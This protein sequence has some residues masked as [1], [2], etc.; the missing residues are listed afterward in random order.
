MKFLK[1]FLCVAFIFTIAA[2]HGKKDTIYEYPDEDSTSEGGNLGD[3]CKKNDDCKDGLFCINK[4]CSKPAAD[5]DIKDDSDTDT[6]TEDNETDSDINDEDADTGTIDDSDTDTIDDSDSDTNDEDEP[7][8]SDTQPDGDNDETPYL[9]ECGNGITEMGEECDNG[10]ANSDEPGTYNSTCRTNCRFARCGDGITD[11]NEACDDGNRLNGDYCSADCSEIIGYCGDGK[12]QVEIE[13]CD[14]ADP[15][16]GNREGIGAYCAAD[17]SEITGSCGDGIVQRNEACDNAEPGEGGGQG[18]GSHYCSDN[19]KEVTGYCG[20]GVRQAEIEEC[21]DGTNNGKYGSCNTTCSGLISCGDGIVQPAYEKCDDGNNVNGDYCSADCQTLYGACGDGIKQDGIEECDTALDPYCSSDCQSIVG[22]CGDGEV[23]GNEE[24]DKASLNGNTGCSYGSI[25]WCE[26]CST[27]CTII[28]GTPIYCGDG[29]IQAEHYEA[30]DDGNNNNNDYCSA[31]CQT[32]TGSCGDGIKQNNEAC[33]T[34]LDPYCSADCKRIE[35]S[36]GDGDKNGN[37]E[38]DYGTNNGNMDCAYDENCKVCTTECKEID[39]RRHYCG[40]HILDENNENCD[41]GIELNG[42]YNQCKSD[43]SGIGE[44]CG[45]GEKNG[46]E[47]CD[48]GDGVNGTITDCAYNEQNCKVCNAECKL[49]DGNTSTC[50]DGK[51]DEANGEVC[52]KLNDPYCSDECTTKI[53]SCGDGIVQRQNCEGYDNCTTITENLNEACDD[54]NND[55]NDYCSSDCQTV[56]GSCG[57]ETK[58]RNEFCESGENNGKYKLNYPPYCNE[59]CSGYSGY[60][61][62]SR[63]QRPDCTGYGENC[64]P[65]DD[66]AEDCDEG[67]NNGKTNCDYNE[68]SCTVCTSSCRINAG[69][70]SLCGDGKL[71]TANEECDNADP[72]VGE[73]QG[74]GAYCSDNC[75]QILGYCGDGKIQDNEVCDKAEPDVGEGEGIGAY[76]KFDCK[77]IL[78]YCGD[79]KKQYNEAC[80]KAEPDVGEG[81]GTGAYCSFDCKQSFGYCGDGKTND[82]VEECD[83]GNDD[84]NDYCSSDCRIIGYCGDGAIQSNEECDKAEPGVGGN[85]G[86]GAYCSSDCQQ[87]LGYC[88]DRK[89]QREDCGT[90]PICDE[91]LTEDCCEIVEG[92]N[93]ACDDGNPFDGDYC[94]SDC[95]T[96][97]GSCGDGKIQREDCGTLPLCNENLTENCCETAPGLDENCDDGILNGTYDKVNPKC[98]TECTDTIRCG[99]GKL[100]AP[101]ETCDAGDDNGKYGKCNETCTGNSGYCGDGDLQRENC[102]GYDSNCTQ[103]EG[104]EEECDYGNANNGKTDCEYSF[105]SCKVC[106]AECKKENGQP[107]FCGD[108]KIQ[109]GTIEACNAYVAL[110]PDNNKLCDELVTENCCE[111][112]AK[113]NE[114]CDDGSENG[115][116]GKC[117]E[118]CREIV[119]WRCGDGT[120]DYNHGETCDSGSNNGKPGYCNSTCNGMTPY[121]GDGKLQRENCGYWTICDQYIT[122]NCCEVV[123]GMNEKCDDGSLNNTES[124]CYSDC[125]GYCGDGILQ[126]H[127]CE[128][129]GD[130]CVVSEDVDEACDEGYDFNGEEGHCSRTCDGPTPVCGNGIEEKGE[131]CDDG[132]NNEEDYCSSSCKTIGY[133]GD[134]KIQAIYE[135]CDEG[136][137]NGYH[138]HCNLSCNGTSSCGDGEIGNDELCDPAFVASPGYDGPQILPLQCSVLPQFQITDEETMITDCRSNCMPDFSPCTYDKDNYTSPFFGTGQIFCYDNDGSPISPCPASG[139]FYGQDPQFNYTAHDFEDLENNKIVID[140]A[141][142]LIWQTETPNIYELD[143]GLPEYGVQRCAAQSSCTAQEAFYYCYFLTIGSYSNWRLPT[144]VEL[145]TIADYASDKHL[146]SSFADSAHGSYWTSDGFQFSSADGTSTPAS[147]ETAQ[148]KCVHQANNQS[149]CTAFQCQEPDIMYDFI[150][151][152]LT[153]SSSNLNFWYFGNLDSSETWETALNTCTSFN[154]GLNDMRLP[155]VNELRWFINS[156]FGKSIIQGFTGKAW[157]ST[158]VENAPADPLNPVV[159]QSQA[160]A[161][162]FETGSVVIESKS[163]SNIVICIE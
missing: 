160:Y 57:D 3:P 158:T 76:C 150:D 128:G 73:H 161:V 94:S 78:G 156:D 125:S 85:E 20:D 97:Y 103:V 136:N 149:G 133:C 22:N 80:D 120:P 152:A 13:K 154:N 12:I 24:C 159:T 60:C 155:N 142:G 39:G 50:G 99:D 143:T 88:G 72:S 40:D 8:D 114:A 5:E 83:D 162:D 35:G 28:P 38:C 100:Q 47:D 86:T 112:V 62:D 132:N 66:G 147:A 49:V 145:L 25:E 53:G 141:S 67:T 68:P 101:Y 126:K 4:V 56:T 124:Y 151:T 79:G 63:I 108:K 27:N 157:T 51:I 134:G 21:D 90:L 32:V 148:I 122:E 153:I 1:I 61:G 119:T 71:D 48:L 81:E 9:P 65:A 26:V 14:N 87:T 55:E 139:T 107:H 144:A 129:Y 109:K 31:D 74:I 29:I 59:N 70:T 2:C 36:C 58:Q 127:N 111:V 16:V 64:D 113:A 95:Q 118:K 115:T 82:N 89:L 37:E 46:N 45:D 77:Q 30:C 117:D 18:T 116:F 140:K 84:E 6:E 105:T 130:N 43:C 34:A 98:N 33:D 17:C 138:G 52:D 123:E 23:N 163:N 10:F 96:S 91:E 42:K 54:G 92:M 41:D 121:C 110:D 75:Q 106:T 137:N 104:A 69:V 146:Y 44:H 102:F 11:G 93:E 7:D 135:T 19:C 131:E 15:N